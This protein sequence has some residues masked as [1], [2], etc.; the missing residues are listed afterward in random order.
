MSSVLCS[1]YDNDCS[2]NLIN[3]DDNNEIGNVNG[4]I[5][6]LMNGILC[7]LCRLT[8]EVQILYVY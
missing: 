1:D 7:W 3:V 6:L 4:L 8:V 5:K 2:A